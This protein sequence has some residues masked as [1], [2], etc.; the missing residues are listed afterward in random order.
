MTR[1]SQVQISKLETPWEPSRSGRDSATCELI[2]S[3][4]ILLLLRS[5]KHTR[6]TRLSSSQG[7]SNRPRPTQTSQLLLPVVNVLQYRV[8]YQRIENELHAMVRLLTQACV[9]NKLYFNPVGE[10]GLQLVD[11]LN[12]EERSRIGGDAILRVNKQYVILLFCL[13]L[14]ICHP[15]HLILQPYPSFHFPGTF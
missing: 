13:I 11:F 1:S 12:A 5:H 10:T 14:P 15:I 9:P 8:F 4:L 3:C 2:H 6:C 7:P